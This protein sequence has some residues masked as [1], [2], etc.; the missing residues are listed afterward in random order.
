MEKINNCTI[1][2]KDYDLY[3]EFWQNDLQIVDQ[4]S[5]S[6]E[7]RLFD[8]EKQS[9]GIKSL[10][11]EVDSA[12]N[13][14]SAIHIKS[15]NPA[16]R[17]YILKMKAHIREHKENIHKQHTVFNII[18]FLISKSRDYQNISAKR[19]PSILNDDPTPGFTQITIPK[20][21]HSTLPYQWISFER[22]GSFFI[23]QY[24]KA[25]AIPAR[26]AH[27]V[28]DPSSHEQKI[29]FDDHSIIVEDPIPPLSPPGE[30]LLYLITSIDSTRCFAAD[31]IGKRYGSSTDI[32]SKR[33]IPFRVSCKSAFG[34]VLLGGSRH[35]YLRGQ[36]P[37]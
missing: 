15:N 17:D 8:L 6:L 21:Y 2:S 10:H 13:T 37:D 33:I 34:G 29:L 28:L 24:K 23:V 18:N 20:K 9:I 22:N 31:R 14:L 5:H 25:T 4:L 26:C 32:L 12:L 7:K 30:P 27:Y 35:I 11:D 3:R 16:A 36:K 19:F 1:L